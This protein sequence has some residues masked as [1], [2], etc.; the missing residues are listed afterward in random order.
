[1]SSNTPPPHL[2]LT[3]PANATSFK[4]S[5]EQLFDH[6]ESPG[7]GGSS[8][9]STIR[10]GER[11]KR[12]RGSESDEDESSDGSYETS[13]EHSRSGETTPD[14]D[15]DDSHHSNSGAVRPPD[16][17]VFASEN[18]VRMPTAALD[19]EMSSADD[20]LVRRALATP[21][22]QQPILDDITS[23]Q[24]V[25]R[26]SLERYNAFDAQI[27]ALRQSQSV[28]PTP[29]T[30]RSTPV[31]PPINTN[32]DTPSTP[33]STSASFLLPR[34]EP[35]PP[36][37]HWFY[38]AA[39]PNSQASDIL[40][41]STSSLHSQP[42]QRSAGPDTNSSLSWPPSLSTS[43][44]NSPSSPMVSNRRPSS[45]QRRAQDQTPSGLQHN[46]IL[47]FTYP[48]PQEYVTWGSSMSPIGANR[49]HLS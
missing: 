23:R 29:R 48:E 34:S 33:S 44:S 37:P 15:V 46:Y 49:G 40:A 3:L 26:S 38:P 45:S 31:P 11:N 9:Q 14:E 13:P 19:V 24:D 42:T 39:R 12:A 16:D 36:L 27:S 8:G 20:F 1:M 18:A 32:I 2:H 5:F 10:H 25:F 17:G 30:S 43:T 35:S 7:A 41:R 21:P 4:R 6:L 28:S 22:Q 47:G